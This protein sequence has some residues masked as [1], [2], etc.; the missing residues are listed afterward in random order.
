LKDGV[1]LGKDASN[2]P[3][4]IVLVTFPSKFK[5]SDFVIYSINIKPYLLYISCGQVKHGMGRVNKTV[6]HGQEEVRY[7]DNGK[8][9]GLTEFIPVLLQSQTPV[10]GAYRV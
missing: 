6:Y 9:S 4:K 2:S 10:I 5:V 7:T 3:I 8:R 1:V